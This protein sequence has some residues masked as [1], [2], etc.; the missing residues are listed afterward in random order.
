MQ[1]DISVQAF[2]YVFVGLLNTGIGL[3]FIY[4]FLFFF[5][6]T[7]IQANFCGYALGLV[8]SYTLHKTWTF[9]HTGSISSSLPKYVVVT[10][11]AYLANLAVVVVA[12]R[13]LQ[14]NVYLAQLLGVGVYVVVGFLGNRYV[15]FRPE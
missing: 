3:C 12:H 2:R 13:Q 5:G 11:F 9:Q 7:D 10:V 15:S 4:A 6:L 14:V 1:Q 8:V